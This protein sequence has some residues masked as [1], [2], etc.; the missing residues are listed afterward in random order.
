M[1]HKNI[2][3]KL[4]LYLEGELPE[5]EKHAIESHLKSCEK[6]SKDFELLSDTWVLQHAVN[7]VSPPES[8][9][10]KISE[11]LDEKSKT[12]Y[13]YYR[14]T[15]LINQIEQPAFIMALIIAALFIGIRIGSSLIKEKPSKQQNYI[16]TAQMD[17]E[18]GLN[19]FQLLSS[20]YLDG[21]MAE[22]MEYAKK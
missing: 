1:N 15:S 6:C 8:I 21:K 10:D 5:K 18:F 19:N 7:R 17:N 14:I 16:T 3:K 22:L 2:R 9:W 12:K 13:L 4:L 20:G 11:R